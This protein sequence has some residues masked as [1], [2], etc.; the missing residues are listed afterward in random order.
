MS[1]DK[2]LV[3]CP[4]RGTYNKGE[5]GYL[6]RHHA[7]RTDLVNQIDTLRRS[8]GQKSVLELD[9]MDTYSLKLHTA[10]ENASALIYACAYEDFCQI[11]QDQYDIVA[12]TGNSMGWYITLALG[13]AISYKDG[14]ELI[15]TMGGITQHHGKL[16]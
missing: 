14:F 16:N 8:L 12:V 2:V 3:V 9:Q 5:L 6:N 1:K 11:N 10:G 7:D 15:Q 13:G 4:G